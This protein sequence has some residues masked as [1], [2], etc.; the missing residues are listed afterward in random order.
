MKTYFIL[1][2]RIH[3]CFASF[4]SNDVWLSKCAVV[5]VPLENSWPLVGKVGMDIQEGVPAYNP[6]GPLEDVEGYS[7][8]QA[9]K[10]D[11][12]LLVNIYL[13]PD[14]T[15]Y[16]LGLEKYRNKNFK[17][18]NFEEYVNKIKGDW[19]TELPEEFDAIQKRVWE[20][21]DEEYEDERKSRGCVCPPFD[22]NN[23]DPEIYRGSLSDEVWNCASVKNY[24]KNGGPCF[25]YIG[26]SE[27]THE[28]DKR[29]LELMKEYPAEF[30]GYFI[31]HTAGRHF[32][33]QLQE[34]VGAVDEYLVEYMS[35]VYAEWARTQN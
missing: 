34:G 12:V 3:S 21:A 9:G 23:K 28:T 25:G 6:F 20:R 29:L 22:K 32:A 5:D 35:P 11:S 18:P 33:D 8:E 14:K 26:H 27:R 30:I 10:L 1:S 19:L 4:S 17:V 16:E 15:F 31:C 7:V 2:R 13:K 24:T